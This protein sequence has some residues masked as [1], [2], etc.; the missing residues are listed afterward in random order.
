M[1]AS[2]PVAGASVE[3]IVVGGGPAGAASAW[4][5][6]RAGVEVVVLERARF[7]RDKPCA[8]YVSPQA[9]RILAEMGVLE[10]IE[11]AGAAHLNGMIVRAPNGVSFR[12]DFAANHPFH[13]FRDRGLGIRR[14]LLDQI[15]LR[16]AEAA[17]ARVIEGAGVT[18]LVRDPHGRVVGVTLRTS[19]ARGVD[20]SPP[21]K[22]AARLVVG[23][24]GLHSVVARRLGVARTALWPHRVAFVTHYRDVS[25]MGDAGEMYVERGGYVGFADVGNG[26]TNVALVVP[27]R[28][29][30]GAGAD[31]PAFL[32]AWMRRRPHL[33]SRLDAAERTTPVRATGPF[34]H[35]TSRAWGPGAALV[36]DAADFFDPFTGEGIYA[37]LRG[38]ELLAPYVHT[39][40]RAASAHDADTALAAYERCRRDEFRGKWTVERIIGAVVAAPPLINHAARALSRD[41]DMAD[42][43][44]GVTGDFVPPKEILRAGFLFRLLWPLRRGTRTS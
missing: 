23:A 13:G 25:G 38:A 19:A 5:L 2:G 39:A 1:T 33:M 26:E 35:Y 4:M 29:A 34:A 27:A 20:R 40:V 42:L 6:A 9:L 22:L 15:L 21:T 14:P 44:V 10:Q 41:R 43:L 7:P 18:D 30:R 37:A 12:G 24:D 32:G 31:R 11:A 36:G 28:S 16:Q 17:G 8:E 3:V